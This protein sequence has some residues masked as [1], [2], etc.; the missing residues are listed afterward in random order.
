MSSTSVVVHN[1]A[2]G[3]GGDN[4]DI[5]IKAALDWGASRIGHAYAHTDHDA[6]IG[7]EYVWY[8]LSVYDGVTGTK[9]AEKNGVYGDTGWNFV[10][11]GNGY[12]IR[13]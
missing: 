7:C 9:L 6:R 11:S 10:N 8:D 2:H 5:Y 1:R 4:K 12:E 3:Q 13:K